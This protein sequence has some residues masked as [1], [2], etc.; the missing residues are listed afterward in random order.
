M[1]EQELVLKKEKIFEPKHIFE[2]GQCFRWNKEDDGSYTGVIGKNVLNVKKENNEICFRGMCSID[3]RQIVY[4]YFDF[5]T[6]YTEI[7]DKLKKV[8]IYLKRSI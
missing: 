8:D 7:Q 1:R 4:N 5:E 3:I 2:C 6:N